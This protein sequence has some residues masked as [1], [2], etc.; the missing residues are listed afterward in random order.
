MAEFLGSK[1]YSAAALIE[2]FN[3]VYPRTA[4]KKVQDKALA[5]D[6]LSRNARICYDAVEAQ[7]GAK[8]AEGSWWQAFNAV[9]YVTD[10]VQ[11]RS[12]DSRLHSAWFGGNQQ[13]KK[14]ALET[15]IKF[16]EVA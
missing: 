7:P 11:G 5:I 6:T 4:D 2:Y 9:T 14:S 10:H 15:A 16:A 8:Y 3:T 13:R 12:A 1:R